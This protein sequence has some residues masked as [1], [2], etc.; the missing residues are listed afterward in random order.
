MDVKCKFC[1]QWKPIILAVLM[2]V[3]II[4]CLVGASDQNVSRILGVPIISYDYSVLPYSSIDQI[5]SDDHYV[6][7]LYG[8]HDGNVQ[9]FTSDGKYQ[10]SAY[11]YTHLNGTFRIAAQNGKLYVRDERKNVYIL[12]DGELQL[13]VKADDAAGLLS[14]V[15]FAKHS[16]CYRVRFGSVYRYEGQQHV[17]II[18]RPLYAML[19]QNN[20]LFILSLCVV[21]GLGIV[22]ARKEFLAKSQK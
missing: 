18:K 16:D 19:Y 17:C 22:R 7:I 8:E 14:S 2:V 9:V 11:F 1:A 20:F 10:Y 6:Y 15:N 21:G 5:V 3:V 12:K 13:F 4:N